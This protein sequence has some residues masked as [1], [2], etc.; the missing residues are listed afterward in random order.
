MVMLYDPM[1]LFTP[2]SLCS[3]VLGVIVMTAGILNEGRFFFS[4]AAIMLFIAALFTYLMGLIAA[5]LVSSRIHYF[6]DESIRVF[7]APA[8]VQPTT[9]SESGDTTP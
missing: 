4:N 6:G 9:A 2:L 3:L 8:A 7:D 1:R 5:Q